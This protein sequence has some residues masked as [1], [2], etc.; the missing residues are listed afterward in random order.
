MSKSTS[1]YVTNPQ[2]S[3]APAAKAGMATMS[4]LGKGYGVPKK[5]LY[6]SKDLHAASKAKVPD[7]DFPG[8]VYTVTKTPVFG[9]NCD[10]SSNSPTKKAKRL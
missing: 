1:R 10:T 6:N 4:S 8:G 2:F 9:V 7:E 3:M 5:S